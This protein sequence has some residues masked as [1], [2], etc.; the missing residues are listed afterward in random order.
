MSIEPAARTLLRSSCFCGSP[1]IVPAIGEIRSKIVTPYQACASHAQTVEI[2]LRQIADIEP[3]PFRLTAV[4]D[5]ELKQDEAF[6]RIAVARP[7]FEM[8]AQLLV[9]FHEPEIVKAGRMGQA[10]FEA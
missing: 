6:T 3:Q 1:S 7:G 2:G 4:F 9:G 10:T 5:D 8:D